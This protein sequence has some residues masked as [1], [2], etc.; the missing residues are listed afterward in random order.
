MK[1]GGVWVGWGLGDWSHHPDGSDRDDTVRRA[2]AFMRRKFSSYA[3]H[4]ADTNK[5]D[6][7]MHDAVWEMQR[8]YF[9]SG[10]LH[11]PTGILDL[12]TQVVM[13]FKKPIPKARPVIFT[14]EGH[15]SNMWIGPC[16]ETARILEGQGVCRWQPVGYNS[17]SLPFDKSAQNEFRRL[18]SDTGLLPPGTGWGMVIYSRGGIAGSEVFMNDI[19]PVH[20]SLH[21]RLKDL[22]RVVAFGNPWRERDKIAPWIPTNVRPKDGTQGISDQR[23]ERTPDFWMEVAKTGD[24][25]AENTVDDAGENKTAIYKIV[26]NEW[27]GGPDSIFMQV[28]EV[29]TSPITETIAIIKAITS[30]IMFAV[31]TS[32]HAGFDLGPVIEHMRGV[33]A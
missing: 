27:W 3:G 8:R 32:P 1:V 26:Q 20:G 4:L 23:M 15:M 25:Y 29:A 18:L 30:G 16:A 2:K 11:P 6:K 19:L 13:G 10:K 21:W 17:A 12:D 33:A 24:I 9:E 14:I 31:N 22:K 28:F 7:E 5:F